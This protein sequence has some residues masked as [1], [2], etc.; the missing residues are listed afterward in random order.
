[1]KFACFSPRIVREM[2]DESTKNV[3][4]SSYLHLTKNKERKNCKVNRNVRKSTII[5]INSWETNFGNLF[6]IID[7]IFSSIKEIM[8]IS[9]KVGYG[10][11]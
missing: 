1:M 6:K 10:N 7:N 11:T 9:S 5:L 8:Y 2:G 4:G 3:L